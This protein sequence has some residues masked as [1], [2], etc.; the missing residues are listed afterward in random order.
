MNPE[1]QQEHP[2]MLIVSM[3]PEFLLPIPYSDSRIYRFNVSWPV[4]ILIT[5]KLDESNPLWQL[6]RRRK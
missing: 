2:D 4:F 1:I 3:I 6:R 5:L